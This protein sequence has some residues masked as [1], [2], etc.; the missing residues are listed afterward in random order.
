MIVKAIPNIFERK[1]R[2]EFVVTYKTQTVSEW[3]TQT[4]DEDKDN[5][6]PI[7]NGGIAK[8][9][10]I[11]G[12]EDELL[13]VQNI[14]VSGWDDILIMVIVAV[15]VSAVVTLVTQALM[16]TMNPSQG[17]KTQD[18][19]TYGWDGIRN[20]VGDGTELPIVYGRHR[21]G[22][23]IIEEFIENRID[24]GVRK[25][26]L[27]T[28]IALS[29]GEVYEV[30]TS[31]ILLGNNE[32]TANFSETS[33]YATRTGS[34]S[35]TAIN[36]AEL[37]FG[38]ITRYYYIQG[39]PKITK[40]GGAYVYRSNNSI[41]AAVVT[42]R[43]PALYMMY[44]GNPYD[45][46]VT[47]KLSY[48]SN[49]SAYTSCSNMQ[50]VS[51]DFY[52]PTTQISYATRS[53]TLPGQTA[54][55][56]YIVYTY[57]RYT[58]KL[59]VGSG[60]VG[61][62]VGSKLKG[63]GINGDLTVTS[64]TASGGYYVIGLNSNVDITTI[65]SSY[66]N[67]VTATTFEMYS[68]EQLPSIA[69]SPVIYNPHDGSYLTQK[70]WCTTTLT[71][72]STAVITANS[73]SEV[74]HQVTFDLPYRGV[75]Y[76]K[77]E[78]ITDDFTDIRNVGDLYL[79]S[80]EEVEK[81][82]ITYPSTAL[83]GLS[84]QA[85]DRLSGSPPDITT[86]V[87]GRKVA[88]VR[89]LA[90]Y[91]GTDSLSNYNNPANIIYDLLTNKLYG[92]GRYIAPGNVDLA[93]FVEFANWCDEIIP[94]TYTGTNNITTSG[95]QK[96]FEVNLV[97]DAPEKA[98][99]TLTKIADT[100]RST[101]YWSGNKVK[102]VTDK[103]STNYAQMFSMS[104]IVEG[105]FSEKYIGVFE[106]PN[107]FEVQIL[108]ED[109][110]Y[111]RASIVAVDSARLDENV[112]A[113]TIQLYGLTSKVRAKREAIYK[114]KKANG[115]K[116]KIS[117]S[118]SIQAIA[119]EVGDLILF[120]HDIPQY[121]IS[122]HVISRSINQ[123]QLSREIIAEIGK[124]YRLR[125]RKPDNTTIYYDFV[126]KSKNLLTNSMMASTTG[127]SGSNGGTLSSVTLAAGGP[128][129]TGIK[130][131]YGTGGSYITQSMSLA[132]N[133][134][135]TFSVWVYVPSSIPAGRAYLT[136]WYS[137]G[138][139]QSIGSVVVAER[140]QWVLKTLTFVSNGTYA[141]HIV[142]VGLSSGTTGTDY[143][144]GC[145]AQLEVGGYAT[146]I[147]SNLDPFISSTVDVGVT[148]D[149]A[150]GYGCIFQFGLVGKE[151]KPFRITAISREEDYKVKI[152]ASE[153]NESVYSEDGTINVTDVQYSS[154]G[155]ISKY[156]I[157]G[158]IS[159]PNNRTVTT[160]ELVRNA[161]RSMFDIPPLVSD[162]VLA[163][164]FVSVGSSLQSNI[165]IHFTPLDIS[166]ESLARVARYELIYSTD[167]GKSWVSGG[168]ANGGTARIN[169]VREK[170]TYYVLIKS[171]STYNIPNQPETST[172]Q[173]NFAITVAGKLAPPSVPTNFTATVGADGVKITWTHIT[174]A[175]RLGYELREGASWATGSTLATNVAD[176]SF[177]YIPS[178]G[179]KTFRIKAIDTTGNYSVSDA[180]YV[181]TPSLS[182]AN[183][184]ATA[185]PKSTIVS[186]DKSTN[187]SI[188][189]FEVRRGLIWANAT[190]VGT[191]IKGTSIEDPAVTTGDKTYWIQATDYS[192][193]IS[194]PQSFAYSPTVSA[195]TG[196]TAI[197]QQSGIMLS[198]TA[199]ATTGIAGYEVR[200][201]G[202]SWVTA[203]PFANNIAQSSTLFTPQVT[204]SIL[205]RLKAIDVMGNASGE[206]TCTFSP[207]TMSV[208]LTT[209]VAEQNMLRVSWSTVNTVSFAAYELRMNGTD[210]ASATVLTANRTNTSYLFAPTS[211]GNITFRVKA[212]DIYGNY[213]S[214]TSTVFTITAPTIVPTLSTDVVDNN[215]LLKWGA[216]SQGTFPID[217]Y[218]IRKGATWATGT[219]IGTT[220]STFSAIF[221]TTSQTANYWVAPVDILNI[222]G[223]AKSVSATVSQPPDFVLYSNLTLDWTGT[224][225]NCF[226]DAGTLVV[227]PNT[228]ETY[229]A[230]FT[231]HS[232]T[233]PSAQ[234]TAGNPIFIQPTLA[235][236]SYVQ[237]FNMGTTVPS[238][239]ITLDLSNAVTVT[240]TVTITPTISTYNS[241]TGWTDFP[242]G[243]IS[244]FATNF[245][246]VKVT[247]NFA[248]ASN[249]VMRIP[250]AAA[251]L[252]VKLK[253][254][255]DIVAC[256][257]ADSGGTTVY[258]TD[259]KASGGN[260]V[261]IDVQ[262]ISVTP[263]GTTTPLIAIYD[264]T[265]VPNP[266]SFKI[267]LYNTSGARQS[268]NVS[269]I[270]RG[271]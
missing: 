221:E 220:S 96:R 184:T 139:W 252:D 132:L 33:W 80:I 180:Y 22:G 83:L 65:F 209:P 98:I 42:V 158:S 226:N 133:T 128:S 28:L 30:E 124:T 152:E 54:I 181:Y 15:V 107:Q 95:T 12:D 151:A 140:N 82:S 257:A 163:E 102:I 172:L 203:S 187:L 177:T 23:I 26:F 131:A 194:T 198:W 224:K 233:T 5:Y 190:V 269:W 238:T 116:R 18:G 231:S 56:T 246:Q 93:S 228:T 109:D 268:G 48:S 159:D 192:G 41:D 156:S 32:L 43:L 263:Q 7:L 235:T 126:G 4:V 6:L 141:A 168:D 186:W 25:S 46:S 103:A 47:I 125:M 196:F 160:T 31:T 119:C 39:A 242:A 145:N 104:N 153:Y 9:D 86:I 183:L 154:L 29:E 191:G 261:F 249:G 21:I 77:V 149:L 201:G 34:L 16:P 94:Y 89:R 40:S 88:D 189:S 165:L 211:S 212:K 204:G 241:T 155:L 63:F 267:L 68:G 185:G 92:L 256:N 182:V 271:V 14:G 17:N 251:K 239:K 205:F 234:V 49:N 195:P 208:S 123:I 62:A 243:Q 73:R 169:N 129:T 58:N 219:L 113:K 91:G 193:N 248:I 105:S 110:D 74:T 59:I 225:T 60:A 144:Y 127:W 244:V 164:E 10:D 167:N 120:S 20:L 64:K 115:I 213:S 227:A 174:D 157:D 81:T 214:E 247:L 19:S 178:A 255:Q 142:G 138:A 72:V 84:I 8:W 2:L 55:S 199:S 262:A 45:N 150:I 210:W 206:A 13:F 37:P 137:N 53:F 250:T 264:F 136:A 258:I 230:H 66:F 27:N 260:A 166:T 176:N 173:Y 78:R 229:S 197:A 44:E 67:N 1:N 245:S 171:W 223:T 99:D 71:D 188:V 38:Q 101:L 114:M 90:G 122:G 130:I 79:K 61:I 259:T 11:P 146:D 240:G 70:F 254:M 52:I 222:Y 3:F 207:E 51:N 202:V 179:T 148:V 24:G 36:S 57:A 270:V 76:I 265:D 170:G 112:N 75:W 266:T 200:Y 108:D 87:K 85:T 162:I 134:Q 237:T 106:I 69:G 147:V 35:Q 236:A 97:L 143:L 50:E 218:E 121:G 215:V 216:S 117:F 100:C 253:T 118:T 111:K 217:H 175:D 135:H 232:W 161:N